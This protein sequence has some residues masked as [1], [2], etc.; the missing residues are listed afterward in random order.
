MNVIE[1]LRDVIRILHEPDPCTWRRYRKGSLQWFHHG[2]T[3]TCRFGLF[4][5]RVMRVRREFCGKPVSRII[6]DNFPSLNVGLE[7]AS[8]AAQLA[9]LLRSGTARGTFER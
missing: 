7:R 2:K 1:E 5:S 9:F 8:I 4:G 6:F 3:V